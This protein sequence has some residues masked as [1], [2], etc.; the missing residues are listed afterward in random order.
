M[1]NFKCKTSSRLLAAFLSFVMVISMFPLTT[2]TALAETTE[3][4]DAVTVTVV[5][6]DGLPVQGATVAFTID[7]VINGDAYKTGS[8]TTDDKGVV[9]VLAAADFVADD[10]TIAATITADGHDSGEITE[11]AI[12]SAD[13]DIQ[14]VI[15]SNLIKDVTITWNETLEYTGNPLS[16]VSVTEIE[17][18]TIEYEID[19][20]PADKAEKTDAGT[21]TV[22]VTVKRT[23][24]EDLTETKDI[25]IS[26]KALEIGVTAN[27]NLVYNKG[28]QALVTVPTGIAIGDKVTWTVNDGTPEEYIVDE[29]NIDYVP[30][31]TNVGEYKVK[32]SVER[33]ANYTV[34]NSEEMKAT[35]SATAI[36]NLSAEL[37]SGLVYN[38][39]DQEL[40]KKNEQDD[41][42]VSGLET[43]DKVYFIVGTD[44]TTV[45]ASDAWTEWTES[46][47]PVGKDAATYTVRIKVVRTNYN[48][49]EVELDPTNVTIAKA[50][51]SLEF[52][53]SNPAEV[54]IDKNDA[55]NNIYDFAVQGD[56]LSGNDVVYS[57]VNAN[58]A[59]AAVLSADGKLTI[60]KAGIVTVKAYR[61]GNGNY[62]DV[63]VYATVVINAAEETLV[64]FAVDNVP[65]V[66]NENK[67]VSSEVATKLYPTEDNGSLTY[68]IDKT[69]I[70]LKINKDSG[71][72]EINNLGKLKQEMGHSGS[73]SVVVTVNKAPGTVTSEEWYFNNIFDWGTREITEEVYPAAS[74]SYTVQISYEAAPEF[75]TVCKIEAADPATG[76]YN[77]TYPATVSPIDATKYLVSLDKTDDFKPSVTITEQG[78]KTHYIY[79]KDK[80][81]G[82][83]L[84]GIPI[85][86][87]V[88][89]VKPEANR[90]KIEYAKSP[91]D[92]FLEVITLGFYNPSVT[93]RFTA[94]D[95]TSGIDYFTWNYTKEDGAS[96][97]NHAAPTPNQKVNATQ[98]ATDGT[99]YIGEFTITADEL[100][101]YRGYLDVT[102]TDKANNTSDVKEDSGNI[103]VIDTV[104]PEMS[105]KYEGAE[106]YTGEIEAVGSTHY[107][108]C[109]VDVELTITEANFYSENVD[110]SVTKDGSPYTCNVSWGTR[111]DED[112]TVGTFTLTGDGDYVVTVNAKDKSGNVMT[113]YTSE[114]ITVDKTAPVV[115]M[116]YVHNGEVQ[117]TI[118]TV[119]EHNFRASDVVITGDMKDIAGDGVAFTATELTAILQAATW[120]DAGNDTYTY[121]YDQYVNGI[122]DLKMDYQDVADWNATQ[123]VADQFIIDHGIPTNVTIEYAK[124]PLDT[125]LE[126]ITLGFYNPSVTVRF[127][128]YDTSSGVES[129]TWSYKKQEGAS[130][131]DHPDSVAET[132]VAATQDSTDKTKFTAT[133]T[134]TAEEA[135]QYRGSLSVFATD[136]FKN[137][138][139]TKVDNGNVIVV[140]NVAP[141]MTVEYSTAD[142]VVDTTKTSYYNNDILVTFKVTEANF[143][144][145][146]VK[147]FVSKDGGAPYS[148]DSQ[149][150]WGER[151][152]N[153]LT[154]GTMTL[155]APADHTGDGDYVITVEY[156]DKSSNVMTKYTSDVYTIDTI[157]PV[158]GVDYK[159]TTVVN[160]LKDKDNNDRKYFADTQTAVVTI[161]EHNF[162]EGEVDFTIIAK[163]VTGAELDVS[164]LNTKTAWSHE[165]DVHTITITYPGD[166]NYTFDVKYTDLATNEAADYA[167]DYFTVDKTDAT[168]LTV[169]YSTSVLDTVLESLSFGFYN[170]KMTV[171]ITAE[172]PTSGV[173]SFLYSYKNAPGVSSVNAELINQAIEAADIQYSE[174]GK[175][176]TVTFEIPKMVLG[177]DNQFN[178]TVEFTAT[179]RSGN[180]TDPL[181]DDTR[182]VV[183]NIAPT[184]QVGYNEATNVVGDISYY[185]GNINAT[186]TIT[187][188]NF[189]ANDVQ[190]MVSKDGGAATAVAPTWKD[191]SVDVHVGTFTLTEDGDYVVTINY[192]DK[193]SNTMA[194]YTSKQM[195]IDTK[196]EAPTY[197]V[198]GEAKTEEGGA[199]KGDATIG[200]NF[201]DQN[202]DTKTIKLTRTRFDSVEDV[203]EEFI[204]VN[205]VEKGGNGTFTIPSEVGNDGIYILTIGMTDKALHT[206]ESQIKF[207]INRYGSVY[208]YNDYLV[209]LIKDGG[210]YITISGGEKA[211]ITDD[212][213]ITEYNADQLLEGSLKILITRDGEAVEAV[214][215]TNPENIN[216]QVGVGDSG[217]YQ[218]VYTISASN[219]AEDGVYRITLSSQYGA[220]DSETNDSTSVPDNSI[221]A[222]GNKILD[223]MNFTVDT[224]APEIRNIVN[225][226]EAIINA[227][228]VD[229]KYTIVDVG[230]LK[231]IEVILNGE[232]IDTITEF[233]DSAFNYSGQFT[234]NESSSAQTVQLKVTDLAGNVTDTASDDFSTGDLYVFNDEVTVS[235]NFFV[236]WYANT[237]LFWG[238]IG[239]VIVLAGAAFALVAYKRK[240]KEEK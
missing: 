179:D 63:E 35:I 202:F 159:N 215:A 170:A 234:I 133:I 240:K 141:T 187:E 26:P 181:K 65:Y 19:G 95:V 204:K 180:E 84:A 62:E 143:Y 128:A 116:E 41:S 75:D 214:Y 231:S 169:S 225:L 85:S 201:E 34:Y 48:A 94:Y 115:K 98:D 163:D 203:T 100:S 222:E 54:T 83:M 162:V 137:K 47:L 188:A 31:A 176:A 130:V 219:F 185:N 80:T 135:A 15:K 156:T 6:D 20:Q 108:N 78:E 58:P 138:S 99:K 55:A 192:K 24:K 56:N 76:W 191:N 216:N 17:G 164:A 147:V 200:F 206:T 92:Q 177:N 7:S 221:D 21:Y 210:Q 22:K 205:D 126:V 82:N 67:T 165:G 197:T 212:L 66:L 112:K 232:T 184:A 91:L 103:F 227:Q 64:S 153:D 28:E 238:S 77:S 59:N 104:S 175:K 72:L 194:T 113:S 209:S 172:D 96:S 154:V 127:T 155:A 1:S 79:L 122:Y 97:I 52:V 136:T 139:V 61:Q 16:L 49:T 148:V 3:H 18:D 14:G 207:T 70:G 131:I 129:F 93:V 123:Y 157:A 151:D 90:I 145:E 11:Q 235:T 166:A 124:T 183:D 33:N 132:T 208:E 89:T 12:V 32:L 86:V 51:Q 40:V 119:T 57:M 220:S 71:V 230:G 36:E 211:A 146:D 50:S 81:T 106:P 198:N 120:T 167:T 42:Y 38:G 168:N 218:Y 8:L 68:S 10:L 45:M 13:Q 37:V 121:E 107:F 73:V 53:N 173:H 74:D 101:Q 105:I 109:D 158:I 190:V 46:V 44:E 9:E 25:T 152:E 189:Y 236:R 30:V 140:D 178:G 171:T 224:K 150:T 233:G 110:V 149:I 2:M 239:G 43:G 60:V 226:E 186:V 195:T 134:I 199:Y 117:K 102:A 174:D 111:N 193:S 196:I 237:G 142:R 27:T 160:T 223:T 182:I 125:F 217:W 118:F 87:K 5:D 39:A 228:T 88:D 114:T 4:P 161:N 229:V 213:V 23:D 144:S 29:N 69:D